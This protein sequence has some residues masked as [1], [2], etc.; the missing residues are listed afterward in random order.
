MDQKLRPTE[1][2]RTSSNYRRVFKTR[3]RFF[4]PV[5]RVHYATGEHELS[6]LGLVVSR[7]VGRSHDRS[8]VKRLLREVYRRKKSELP[9]TLDVVLVARGRPASYND[10]LEAFD[11]FLRFV[12]KEHQGRRSTDRAEEARGTCRPGSLEK[13]R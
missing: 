9:R 10:Y 6:R 8:R 11:L 2:L 3:R 12:E 5:L 13:K 4:S 1:R 7:K